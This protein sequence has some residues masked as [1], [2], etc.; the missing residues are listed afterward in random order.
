MGVPFKFP[1][2]VVRKLKEFVQFFYGI[3]KCKNGVGQKYVGQKERVD[4]VLV[5]LVRNRILL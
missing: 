4:Y 3:I 5:I 2:S 1:G